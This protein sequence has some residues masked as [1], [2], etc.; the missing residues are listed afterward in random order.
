MKIVKDIAYNEA[1]G[2]H[3]DAYLPAASVFFNHCLFSRRR[4]RNWG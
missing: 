1:S 2:C 3:L 4:F